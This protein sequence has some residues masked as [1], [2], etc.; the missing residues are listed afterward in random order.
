MAATWPATAWS[1]VVS[2]VV[3]WLNSYFNA[4]EDVGFLVERVVEPV[5]NDAYVAAV[6]E[7]EH[8]AP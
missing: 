1:V 8:W 4:I 7:A 3:G 6:P 5:P 2:G